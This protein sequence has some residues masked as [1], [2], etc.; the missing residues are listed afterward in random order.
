MTGSTLTPP[1]APNVATLTFTEDR[2]SGILTQT[3]V[4]GGF[5]GSARLNQSFQINN[6]TATP[7]TI[8]LFNYVD[9]DL[10]NQTTST[11]TLVAPG[12]IRVVHGSTVG[13]IQGD[14]VTQVQAGNYSGILSSL[15][16]P[17]V[18]NLN[19]SGFPFTT[20]D[21][22]SALQWDL[23]IPGNSSVTITGYL[24]I[25]PEPGSMALLGLAA[26]GAGWWALRRRRQARP[27]AE[28][29]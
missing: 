29:A 11:A 6:P 3:L 9:F 16:S 28:R 25:V 7:L 24:E 23:I 14:G 13:Y 15:T 5:A 22:T 17:G 1:S 27:A 21:F 26:F 18:T 12:L 8:T 20:G 4:D 10:D 19:G 2:F